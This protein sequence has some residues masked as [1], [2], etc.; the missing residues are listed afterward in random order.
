MKRELVQ[1][2]DSC[3]GCHLLGS[4]EGFADH[5]YTCP[6]F[7]SS[8]ETDGSREEEAKV[9]AQMDGWFAECPKWREI[10]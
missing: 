4:E 6:Y 3:F 8:F 9:T 5:Y 1:E 7:G 2:I 10:E